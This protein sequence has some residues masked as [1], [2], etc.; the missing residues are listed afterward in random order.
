MYIPGQSAT[1]RFCGILITALGA[2][3]LFGTGFA[4]PPAHA[5]DAKYS[6]DIPSQSLNDAL[7]A[8]ALASQHKLLYSSELVEGR[9]SPALKGQFTTEEA[10]K[11]LLSGTN[12]SYE[13]T[14]DGLVLIRAPDAPPSTHTTDALP[15]AANGSERLR[16]AQYSGP[17]AAP[18]ETGDPAAEP[19]AGLEEI[20]VTATKRTERLEDIPM[21]I[22]AL[23]QE[24]ISNRNLVNMDDYLR[25]TPGVSYLNLGSGSNAIIIRGIA[26]DPQYGSFLSSEQTVS[27][28]FGEVP[29][30][31]LRAGGSADLQLVD[32]E[33]VEVLR[34]P[35]GTLYGAD[36]LSGTVRNIPAQPNLERTEG[37]VKAGYSDTAGFGG[38]NNTMQGMINIPLVGDTLAIRAVGYRFYDSGYIEN[39]AG[40]NAAFVAA[41]AQYGAGNLAR[42]QGNIGNQQFSGGRVTLL[43]KP[44]EGLSA[45]LMYIAQDATQVGI[46]EVNTGLGTFDQERLQLGAP[47]GGSELLR[48]ATRIT[49]LVLNYDFGWATLLSS[50][51][52]STQS[53]NRNNDYSFFFGGVPTATGLLYETTAFDEEIR[54]TSHLPGP[55]QFLAGV[56]YEDAK[57]PQPENTYYT[58]IPALNPFGS[59]P[60]LIYDYAYTH[61]IQTSGFG[62]AYY[63]INSQL[64]ATAGFRRYHY[65]RADISETYGEL[66]GPYIFADVN[67]KDSGT[68]YKLDL[69]YKPNTQAMIYALWSQGFQPGRNQ[70]PL[71]TTCI[72]NG[73]VSGTGIPATD[74]EVRSDSLNNYEI[75]G[76]FE[77]L[78][79]RLIVNA[80]IYQINWQGLPVAITPSSCVTQ[81]FVNSSQARSRGVELENI[82]QMTKDLRLD[83]GASYTKAQLTQDAP[84]LGVAGNRLPGSPAFTAS[85][86]LQYDFGVFG[87]NAY[88]RGD[89]SYVG[90]FY[91]NLQ[92]TAPELGAYS[93]VNL[94]A[95]IKIQRAS[96]SLFAKNLFNADNLIWQSVGVPGESYR[97]RPRTVGVTLGY[98]F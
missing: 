91:N 40:S 66:E 80:A 76:K 12:L 19:R 53:W 10:V 87:H 36:A 83:V 37:E 63:S 98:R 45:T 38:E 23:N 39:M 3:L 54:L 89:Y 30:S 57:E 52:R 11:R 26:L 60:V 2:T 42:D 84:N 14:S 48:D 74:L 93:Q 75:G 55:L 97:L 59:S 67:D 58:G 22:T 96:V 47:V 94:N 85:T 62:E 71:P 65:D 90:N 13:V 27:E 68:S 9:K 46:P 33:R 16:L 61:L 6:L 77:V 69:S 29:L 28:Y 24:E 70:T 17:A 15:P 50:T 44:M 4:A 21:S 7:Q 20:L 82:F 78:D 79:K 43:W 35:Q 72:Q 49:N 41:A 5:A 1:A 95:G 51:S 86:G 18:A 8:L 92:E 81:F 31:G 56:Y 73:V 32:M 64:T 34:G 25:T 88:L